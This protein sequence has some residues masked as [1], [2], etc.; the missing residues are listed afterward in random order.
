MCVCVVRKGTHTARHI[1]SYKE[2]G[3][4]QGVVAVNVWCRTRGRVMCECECVR[5]WGRGS[6]R[7]EYESE[8]KAEVE[9]ERKDK[10]RGEC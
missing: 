10:V 7:G 5:V 3:R 1:R 6:V 9:G 4:G 8:N 2:W